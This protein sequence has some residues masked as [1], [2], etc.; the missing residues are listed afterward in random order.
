MSK[1][2]VSNLRRPKSIRGSLLPQVAVMTMSRNE[3]VFFPIWLNYYS[4]FIPANG[5]FVLDHQTTDRSLREGFT[6]T[7]DL[8]QK[9]TG[10]EMRGKR[11][12]RIPVHNEHIF[13][14]KWRNETVFHY[15]ELLFQIGFEAV[16]FTDTDEIIL[17]DPRKARDLGV[18]LRRFLR[19][20]QGFVNCTGYEIFHDRS[21]EKKI[22]LKKKILR[23]RKFYYKNFVY[24]KPL[25]TKKSHS[26]RL[27]HG[28]HRRVDEQINPDPHLFLLHLHKMD[29]ALAKKRH[30]YYAKK[31]AEWPQDQHVGVGKQYRFHEDFQKKF[32]TWWLHTMEAPIIRMPR[33]FARQL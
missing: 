27:I 15:Q 23:Q 16:I 7:I 32:D 22:D 17:P 26:A 2:L 28:F 14:E 30:L 3:K 4:Q 11:F 20:A 6:C 33:A 21:R 18:Y 8:T 12:I 31:I 13:P 1:R 25:L 24:N 19:S 10:A 29:Y 9:I 5:L